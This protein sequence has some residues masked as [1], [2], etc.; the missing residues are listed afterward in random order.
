MLKDLLRKQLGKSSVN[1]EEL[2]TIICDCESYINMRPLT[3]LSDQDEFTALTPQH[4]LGDIKNCQVPEFDY[5]DSIS[6]S[7]RTR[8]LQSLREGL[9]T[10]FKKEYLGELVRYRSKKPSQQPVVGEIVLVGSDNTKRINWPLGKIVK[11]ISGKDNNNRLAIVK[12]SKGEYTRSLQRLYRLEITPDDEVV[13]SINKAPVGVT[14]SVDS[15]VPTVETELSTVSKKGRIIKKPE[16][17]NLLD[18]NCLF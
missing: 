18:L 8:Y 11:F 5:I 10:R 12:T 17:L 6:F 3:Y 2:Y 7:K 9:R 13:C 16:K 14:T 1:E 15:I 4:F